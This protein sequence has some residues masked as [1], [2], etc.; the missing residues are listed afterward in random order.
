V[1]IAVRRAS[2]SDVSTI[3]FA[4]TG[5]EAVSPNAASARTAWMTMARSAFRS[6]TKARK[7]GM[8]EVSFAAARPRIAKEVV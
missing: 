2:S 1:A 5:A 8:I 3:I 7:S 4:N 6:C